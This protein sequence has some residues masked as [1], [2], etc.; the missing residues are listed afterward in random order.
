MTGRRVVVVTGA[1]GRLGSAY[2]RRVAPHADVVAVWYRRRPV[3]PTPQQ[4]VFDPL[5]P[6]RAVPENDAPV[7]AVRADLTD[8]GQIA[9]LVGQVLDRYGRIDAVVHAAAYVH[10]AP[11]LDAG[12]AETSGRAF[13]VGVAAPLALT[14]E[15]ARRFWAG[16]EDENTAANRCV[17]NLSSTAGLYVYTGL[18]QGVY[19]A[20]KAGLNFLSCHMAEEFRALGVRVNALAPDAFPGRVS[21]GSVLDALDELTE[22]TETGRVLAVEPEGRRWI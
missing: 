21:T 10:W 19:S 1:A 11:V 15:V 13:Q 2:C 4:Q 18:G 12:L 20:V 3:L 5:A 8:P 6:D 9:R 17:V 22:G 7:C 16:R 14:A